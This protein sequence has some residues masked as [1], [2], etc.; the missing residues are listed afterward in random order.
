MAT[1]RSDESPLVRVAETT[2]DAT[3]EAFE[4]LSNRTRLAVLLTLWEAREP[5]PATAESDE[6]GLA[7]AE[8]FDRIEYDTASNFS[9]HLEQLEGRFIEQ[10]SDDR[11]TLSISAKRLISIVLSGTLADTPTLTGEP[12]DDPCHHCGEPVVID[13]EE[14]ELVKRCPSCGRSLSQTYRPPA[15]LQHRTPTEFYRQTA[16]WNRCRGLALAAGACP[17][18]AGAVTS[19]LHA[20]PDHDTTETDTCPNCGRRARVRSAYVC[21][22][23]GFSMNGPAWAPAFSATAVKAFVYSRGVDLLTIPTKRVIDMVQDIAV[24]TD[25]PLEVVVTIELAGD[26]LT[27]TLD[28]DAQVVDIEETPGVA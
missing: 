22:V 10:T 17:D 28:D 27:V 20:C 7:F 3:V 4:I 23:C 16:T 11:Y 15:A 25:D 14:K 8:L 18:C 5:S 2:G 6:H 26:R 24:V 19:G 1:R 21:E 13:Y 9:Y 12:I